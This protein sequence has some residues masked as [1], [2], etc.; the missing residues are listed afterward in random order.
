VCKLSTGDTIQAIVV[1]IWC[2]NS[3]QV[4]VREFTHQIIT[5][6][7]CREPIHK[8]ITITCRE[9]THQIMTTIACREFTHKIMT[10]IICREFTHKIMVCKLYR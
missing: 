4:I 9:F 7:T 6:I 8:I 1:I 10:T 5:T 3:L 2:V